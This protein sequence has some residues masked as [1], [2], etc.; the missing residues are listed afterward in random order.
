LV[1]KEVAKLEKLSFD[2]LYFNAQ[3]I[4][5]QKVLAQLI[6]SECCYIIGK[7]EKRNKPFFSGKRP[8]ALVGGLFYLLGYRFGVPINQKEIAKKLHTTDVTIRLSYRKWLRAF[9]DL[10]VDVIGKLAQHDSLK[11]FV[12]LDLK[13]LEH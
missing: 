11:Y 6:A 3:L 10:F 2:E 7:V 8:S 5:G 9:P 13:H 12:L 1:A 4:W